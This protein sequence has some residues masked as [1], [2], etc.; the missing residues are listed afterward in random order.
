ML[1][2]MDQAYTDDLIRR[3]A[4]RASAERSSL[5]PPV[6]E[7][8]LISAEEYLGFRLHPLLR[9]LYAEVA[10]GGF[11]PEY[12]LF[13]LET[14]ILQTPGKAAQ[15][16]VELRDGE[17]RYW[18]LEAIAVMDWG[19]AM[20]AVVDCR[21]PEG[22]V[23]LVDPNA[24]LPDRAKEWFLDS[25]SLARWLESWLDGTGWYCQEDPDEMEHSA[26]WPQAVTRLTERGPGNR[27][28]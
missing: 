14:A 22:A 4:A 16:A 10:D 24:G 12:T 9:R 13:P 7:S 1:A 8:D 6:S 25:E 5:R 18:P 19:C 17:R 28:T 2:G 23:L 27:L 20:N 11:G 3:V 26:P 15:A 21:S